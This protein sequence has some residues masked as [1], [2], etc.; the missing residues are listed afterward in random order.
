M[1]LRRP[2]LEREALLERGS[3][4]PELAGSYRG[5]N[6]IAGRCPCARRCLRCCQGRCLW[7]GRRCSR[8][9]AIHPDAGEIR[10]TIRGLWRRP[11]QVLFSI[12]LAG[13][14]RRRVVR[15]LSPKTLWRGNQKRHCDTRIKDAHLIQVPASCSLLVDVLFEPAR[16]VSGNPI[17]VLLEHHFVAIAGKAG[18]LELDVIGLDARLIQPFG[19]AGIE[20]A[21]ITR[22][23]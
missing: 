21:V 3:E 14:S 19:V 18:V 23:P 5:R 12:G 6:D 7:R 22:L 2:W 10:L 1:Q 15:P 8:R 11:I 16:E 4:I 13:H 20:D 17:A 9:P